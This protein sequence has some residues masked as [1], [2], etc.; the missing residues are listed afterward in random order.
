MNF[1]TIG[2]NIRHF[3]EGMGLSQADVSEFLAVTREQISYY[4]TGRRNIP[5]TLLERLTELFGVELSDLLSEDA[6]MAKVTTAFAFRADELEQEDLE[7]MAAF[8]K[9]VRNYLKIHRLESDS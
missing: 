7:V 1:E 5:L 4:E 9:I 3:R 8:Q 2:L 6:A